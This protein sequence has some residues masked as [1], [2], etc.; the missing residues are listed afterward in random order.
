LIFYRISCG[1]EPVAKKNHWDRGV[2]QM[3]FDACI[4]PPLVHITLCGINCITRFIATRTTAA[5]MWEIMGE[6]VTDTE[7]VEYAEDADDVDVE[8]ARR[9]SKSS[10]LSRRKLKL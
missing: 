9:Q 5:I 3:E 7:D 1:G 2:C 10:I 4:Q 8:D 6:V